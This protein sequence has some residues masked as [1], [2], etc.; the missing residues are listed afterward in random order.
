MMITLFPPRLGFTHD[1]DPVDHFVS[2][3]AAVKP[4]PESP[5]RADQF[6]AIKGP[7]HQG[8]QHARSVSVVLVIWVGDAK[9]RLD[10]KPVFRTEDQKHDADLDRAVGVWKTDSRLITKSPSKV[11]SGWGLV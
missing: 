7:C 2:T 9:N 1:L 8:L 5:L 10:E 6:Y 4:E 3:K 11:C